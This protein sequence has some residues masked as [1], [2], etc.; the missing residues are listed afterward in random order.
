MAESAAESLFCRRAARA[1]SGMWTAWLQV[2]PWMFAN[3][4]RGRARSRAVNTS[5][6]PLSE[7]PQLRPQLQPQ[8]QPHKLLL[9]DEPT[10]EQ[11]KAWSL[12]VYGTY[13]KSDYF[14]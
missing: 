8:Q 10:E 7:L 1:L 14:C 3:I 13:G 4:D 9:I 12:E 5:E 6:M 2:A 11:M